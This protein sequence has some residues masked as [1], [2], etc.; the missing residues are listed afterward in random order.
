[1]ANKTITIT[2]LSEVR[3]GDLCTVEIEGRQYM[4][5]AYV[6]KGDSTILLW[7]GYLMRYSTGKPNAYVTLISATRIIP[8]LPTKLGSAIFI[9]EARG[10]VCYPPV[11]A[12]RNEGGLPP[13]CM[14][15]RIGLAL[16]LNDADITQWQAATVTAQGAVNG[17]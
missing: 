14:S 2:D 13:W 8:S 1:M 4:G 11:L 3:E 16:W 15:R 6:G 9:H 12:V 7:G 5:P 17:Q 10:E